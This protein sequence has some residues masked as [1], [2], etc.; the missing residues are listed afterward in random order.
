MTSQNSL[1]TTVQ[2]N[3][4]ADVFPTE[5][6]E[7]VA[8]CVRMFARLGLL[9]YSRGVGRDSLHGKG[10]GPAS[11]EPLRNALRRQRTLDVAR[12]N[13]LRGLTGS[14]TYFSLHKQAAYAGHAVFVSS[15][16]ESPLGA[17]RF[18]VVCDNL[19]AL[20]DWLATKTVRG[21]P[22]D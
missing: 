10:K 15:D 21:E 1:M 3:V 22:A 18:E 14:A 9:E 2:V 19:P 17:V 6:P 13:I 20:V 16:S 12:A 5:D 8:S 4:S 11:L 7:K